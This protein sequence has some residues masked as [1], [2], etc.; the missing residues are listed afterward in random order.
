MKNRTRT[1]R[2]PSTDHDIGED[3]IHVRYPC[4]ISM[5]MGVDVDIDISSSSRDLGEVS[6]CTSSVRV[7][8]VEVP[9]SSVL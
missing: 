8:A 9:L 5:W 1:L 7:L 6:E 2:A 4:T 3:D